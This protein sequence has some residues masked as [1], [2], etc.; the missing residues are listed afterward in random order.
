MHHTGGLF[1]RVHIKDG[2]RSYNKM[3]WLRRRQ[4]CSVTD[5]NSNAKVNGSRVQRCS[6]QS[7]RNWL[8]PSHPTGRRF[9][10][11]QWLQ[12]LRATALIC[13]DGLCCVVLNNWVSIVVLEVLCEAPGIHVASLRCSVDHI[14][15]FV[16]FQ[17][18]YEAVSAWGLGR[19]Q[20]KNITQNTLFK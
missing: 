8:Q 17:G 9:M 7:I 4:R 20:A 2:V 3:H 1:I 12:I 10:W 19:G 5:E 16:E 18:Y 13:I 6:G 15:S 14:Y 11:L